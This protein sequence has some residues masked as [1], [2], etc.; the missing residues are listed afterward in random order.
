MVEMG[1]GVCARFRHV[2]MGLIGERGE[3][4]EGTAYS[5]TTQIKQPNMRRPTHRLT[6]L[7]RKA[8]NTYVYAVSNFFYSLP[9]FLNPFS[10]PKSPLFYFSL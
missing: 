2:G 1:I 6:E 5:T 8:E 4:R 9:R 10:S 7:D 3:E